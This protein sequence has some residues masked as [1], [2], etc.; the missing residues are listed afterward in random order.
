[1]K[2]FIFA[3]LFALISLSLSAQVTTN[4]D[5]V[6]MGSTSEMYQVPSL[7]AGYTYT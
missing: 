4:P 3:I 5:T 1:M 7:G 6:C 2:K